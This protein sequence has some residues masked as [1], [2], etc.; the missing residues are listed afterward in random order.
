MDDD[1]IIVSKR[2]NS[3]SLY[4]FD[5]Y[6]GDDDYFVVMAYVNQYYFDT[7]ARLD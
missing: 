4:C 3:T 5:N 2:S 1:L 6:M 7:Y